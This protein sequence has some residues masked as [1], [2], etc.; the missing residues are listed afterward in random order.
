M[1][2]FDRGES[3][4]VFTPASSDLCTPLAHT[5]KKTDFPATRQFSEYTQLH[6]KIYNHVTSKQNFAR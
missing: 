3:N 4:H 5:Q 6:G 2:E 1:V